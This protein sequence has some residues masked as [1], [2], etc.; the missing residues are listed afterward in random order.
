MARDNLGSGSAS[1]GR[2]HYDRNQGTVMLLSALFA[3]D[4]HHWF[5]LRHKQ[6]QP[7]EAEAAIAAMIG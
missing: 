7:L 2:L 4:D 5:P 3:A 6:R 1:L